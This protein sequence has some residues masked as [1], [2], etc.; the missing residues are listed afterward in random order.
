[1]TDLPKK[2][3]ELVL[4]KPRSFFYDYRAG[5]EWEREAYKQDIAERREVGLNVE[6][7]EKRQ[8]AGCKF[9]STVDLSTLLWVMLR[10]MDPTLTH[11]AVAMMINMDNYKEVQDKVAEALGTTVT[12]KKVV[13]GKEVPSEKKENEEKN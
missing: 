6:S 10:R 12:R 11:E 9:G 3:V 7:Y 4:D 8:I 5:N 1:M 2:R 13:D